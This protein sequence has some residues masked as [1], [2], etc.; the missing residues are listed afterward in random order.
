MAKMVTAYDTRTGEALPNPV[1]QSWLDQGMFPHLSARKPPAQ[2]D[3]TWTVAQLRSHAERHGIDLTGAT[4]K[5]E[6]L[7]AVTQPAQ[8]A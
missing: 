3:D 4:N 8:E 2:P 6:I 1:P 5:A 7:T